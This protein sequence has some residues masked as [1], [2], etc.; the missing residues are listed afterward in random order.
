MIT[1][2]YLMYGNQDLPEDENT[3]PE[4][5][6][7]GAQYVNNVI[8]VGTPNAGYLDAFIEMVNGLAL[9]VAAPTIPAAV[10]ATLPSYYAML[11]ATPAGGVVLD[12][13]DNVLD[14]FDPEIWIENQWGLADPKQAA[15]LEF[16][17][18]NEKDP[19]K[20]YDIAIDHLRKSLT[21]ARKFTQAI[22]INS[23]QPEHLKLCLFAGNAV[24]TGSVAKVARNGKITVIK[25]DAGDGKVLLT[26]TRYD[27]RFDGDWT[28]PIKWKST[29]FLPAA[30]L[31]ITTSNMFGTNLLGFLLFSS[32]LTP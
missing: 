28:S 3:M 22:A 24:P 17:L 2:Y 19:Q 1:R 18:P 8:V 25:Q 21:Q 13:D 14:L 4:L 26:S 12:S 16:L 23:L 10:I 7:S 6:W 20:R 5:N 27:Q 30:H 32:K 15:T 11:P 31:G 9:N 29:I